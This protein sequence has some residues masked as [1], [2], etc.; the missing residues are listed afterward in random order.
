MHLWTE[1]ITLLH[2]DL[3]LLLIHPN[4]VAQG[5]EVL[6]CLA[7]VPEA[8]QVERSAGKWVQAR[9]SQTVKTCEYL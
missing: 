8:L 2:D 4:M 6:E 7:A 5:P 1:H 3:Y 9:E